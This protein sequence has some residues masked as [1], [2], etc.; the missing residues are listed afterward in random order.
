MFIQIL[1]TLALCLC[2]VY[3]YTQKRN[4]PII[5]LVM[6]A[7]GLVGIVFV[8]NPGLTN[9]LAQAAGVGRGADLILYLWVVASFIVAFNLHMKLRATIGV[10]TELVRHMAI[11]EAKTPKE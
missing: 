5:S 6:M 1:L 11:A 2:F 9:M 3:A 7:T 10:V 8:W 4:A